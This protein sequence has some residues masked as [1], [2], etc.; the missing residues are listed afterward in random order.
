M[1]YIETKREVER[2]IVDGVDAH[3]DDDNPLMWY[4]FPNRQY[5][6]LLILDGEAT[7]D[8]PFSVIFKEKVIENGQTS[9]QP[10]DFSEDFLDIVGYC[11][12]EGDTDYTIKLVGII[13]IKNPKLENPDEEI[14]PPIMAVVI[15]LNGFPLIREKIIVMDKHPKKDNFWTC[16]VIMEVPEHILVDDEYIESLRNAVVDVHTYTSILREENY[17]IISNT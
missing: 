10:M 15:N 6:D 16:E 3:K 13:K 17:P 4:T 2:V 14:I 8:M 7:T 1:A 12:D 9:L 11:Y 5:V